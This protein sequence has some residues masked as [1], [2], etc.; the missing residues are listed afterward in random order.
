[1]EKQ[2]VF[3][4][5]Y[6][7]K[8]E[9]PSKDGIYITDSGENRFRY[10]RFELDTKWWL[11]EIELPSEEEI[12]SVAPKTRCV[13]KFWNGANFILNHLKSNTNEKIDL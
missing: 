7:N 10:H 2:T 3:I 1:M 13:N 11:E 6:I 5:R 4:N 9:R 12:Q 8:G